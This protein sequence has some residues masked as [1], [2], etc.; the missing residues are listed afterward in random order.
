MPGQGSRSTSNAVPSGTINKL[1]V[2]QQLIK[3]REQAAIQQQLIAAVSGGKNALVPDLSHLKPVNLQDPKNLPPGLPADLVKLMNKSTGLAATNATKL[4]ND[5][6]PQRPS[7]KPQPKMVDNETPAQKQ[8]AAKLAL[9][10]QL[11][12]TLLQVIDV[13]PLTY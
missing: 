5:H 4:P 3:S 9:R 2:G 13:F 6:H 12:K 8:A 11:E 7:S 1:T 10:Q